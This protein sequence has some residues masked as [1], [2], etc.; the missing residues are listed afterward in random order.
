MTAAHPW[1]ARLSPTGHHGVLCTPRMA[2]EVPDCREQHG[3]FPDG[4]RRQHEPAFPGGNRPLC[5]HHPRTSPLPLVFWSPGASINPPTPKTLLPPP[6]RRPRLQASCHSP[7]PKKKLSL[8]KALTP[9]PGS[10]VRV[11][12]QLRTQFQAPCV[13]CVH[14]QLSQSIP[15]FI[16][17]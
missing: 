10:R 3:R 8:R 12:A 2:E 13:C 4:D 9:F 14:P 15:V 7:G 6:Q 5:G 17:F 11:E 16:C 1:V